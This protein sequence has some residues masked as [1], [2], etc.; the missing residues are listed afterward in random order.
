MKSI[1]SSILFAGSVFLAAHGGSAHAAQT[2]GSISLSGGAPGPGCLVSRQVP[3]T[4]L[5]DSFALAA[6]TS[7]NGGS[8]SAQVHAD[9]RVPSIGLAG[10]ASNSSASAFVILSDLWTIGVAPG[11][12]VRG[13][14]S[15]P[16]S[17]HLEGDVAPGSVYGAPFGRFLDIGG[18]LGQFG[19]GSG[20]FQ[21]SSRVDTIGHFDQTFTGLATFT[22]YGP[23]V[24]ILGAFEI[25]LTM[26]F[27]Q[28]GAVDFYNT[29]SASVELPPG[30]TVASSSGAALFAVSPVPE[31]E[32]VSMLLVGFGLLGARSRVAS[33]RAVR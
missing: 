20:L 28:A 19:T 11:T 2:G 25:F 4:T 18:S 16:V 12:P 7:C 1:A 22:N 10:T 3:T 14:F 8:D 13:T 6:S 27:L 26:P 15:L 29:L 31:P 21:F 23:G 32:I 17:F 30:F 33:H 9:A 24:P 5:Q